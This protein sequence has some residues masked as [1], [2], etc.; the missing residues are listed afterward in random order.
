MGF[1]K[2]DGT[3]ADNDADG[4]ADWFQTAKPPKRPNDGLWHI[5]SS[6]SNPD[7]A[8]SGLSYKDQTSY[9]YPQVP[10]VLELLSGVAQ[11][12]TA[13]DHIADFIFQIA[14]DDGDTSTWN[15]RGPVAD[16][17]TASDGIPDYDVNHDGTIGNEADR[18]VDL[19]TIQANKEIVFFVVTFFGSDIQKRGLGMSA[20]DTTKVTTYSQPWFTKN[21][22]NPDFGG[23]AANSTIRTLALGCARDDSTCYK[24]AN[25]Q[26]G[27]LD[28]TTINRLK[29]APYHNLTLDNTIATIKTGADQSVPHFVVNA[30][31]SDPT[32]WI[33][34][35]DDQPEYA[36][37][38]NAV[39]GGSFSSDGD[40]ND[41]VFLIERS[42]GGSM[43]STNQVKSADIPSGTAAKDYMV[44]KLRLRFSASYPS[45]GCD[46]VTDADIQFFW[47]VDNVNWYPFGLPQHGT[48]GDIA[49]DVLNQGIVG[50]QVYWKANFLSS[51]Q[52]CQPRL[53]SA[54]MGYEAIQHGEYKFA[55]PV[56]LGNAVFTGSLETTSSQWTVSRNDYRTRGHFY[57][58][59]LFDPTT[60]LDSSVVNWDAGQVLADTA[61]SARQGL[62]TGVN[63]AYYALT[64]A[65][66]TTLYPKILTASDRVAKNNG[67]G[68]LLFDFNNDGV[69]DDADAGYV[70]EWTRGTE[71]PLN[72]PA[73]VTNV[74]RAW[75]LGAVMTSSPAVVG[76]PG[77]PIWLDGTAPALGTFKSAFNG[78][79]WIKNA[80]VMARRTLAIV[81][82]QDGMLHA[83]DAGNFHNPAEAVC[84]SGNTKLVRGCFAPTGNNTTPDYGSGKEVWSF[85]PPTL[86][87]A[88]KN[89]VGP[90][91]GNPSYPEAEVDG[92]LA[93]EDIYYQPSSPVSGQP[94][95]QFVT[96]V[97]ASLGRQW[98]AITAVGWTSMTFSGNTPVST[99]PFPLWKNDWKDADY[100]GSEQPPS[101][102]PA[103]LPGGLGTRF[104][105]VTNSGLAQ[106]AVSGPVKE[107]LYVIDASDGTTVTGGKIALDSAGT[108]AYGF[109][110]FTNLVDSDL[111]G[112]VDRAYNVD[113]AGRVYRVTLSNFQ[114][115]N[116]YNLGEPVFSGMGTSVLTTNGISKV[117]LYVGGGINPDGTGK[118]SPTGTG[119]P[120]YHIFGIEDNDATPGTTCTT[121][122]LVYK[123]NAPNN[124]STWAA[125]FVAGTSV[126]VATSGSSEESVC[127][128][129]SGTIFALSTQGD[130][131]TT[132]P[133]PVGSS[134]VPSVTVGNAAVS[135]I[136]A[137]DGH[138]FVNGISKE[139][140]IVGAANTWN[141]KPPGSSGVSAVIFP[142]VRW[143]EQ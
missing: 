6:G 83:F 34:A 48:S 30:P 133:Q 127:A 66:A 22:L 98:N 131:A 105:V 33:L 136:Q 56:P 116:I 95:N 132:N 44:S 1:V 112:I 53:N 80:T 61:P 89:N 12:K 40:F 9:Y 43:T 38:P 120:P 130:G 32:R 25:A 11:S 115:C 3:L 69:S 35:L 64:S 42:N 72:A 124:Q 26:L 137:F 121:A 59:L 49:V 82:A 36:I 122:A 92:S 74:N 77:H 96:A 54:S 102:G 117:R 85:V 46:G 21:I 111:D 108:T 100:H 114:A 135:S 143:G 45:P 134:S 84:A 97:F 5:N 81:G 65:N 67:N 57:S 87:N 93:A 14:D 41:V 138:L 68:K 142:T 7:L 13:S 128:A 99:T 73:G 47:S 39:G 20:T 113:T 15:S 109:A 23:Y 104:V 118:P 52:F 70:M 141:N 29:T 60:L 107:Y 94:A 4:I 110:G 75:K 86:L 71:Y 58:A 106:P 63:G 88:L 17:S 129:G 50:Q 79:S 62:F 139:T 91:F 16:G 125:P 51:S 103:T 78:T 31:S 10:H 37:D 76:T 27:W 24:A 8:N 119:Y 55:A 19:G 101:V 90:V 18:A 123:Y 126:L 2:A 140:A 28:Q